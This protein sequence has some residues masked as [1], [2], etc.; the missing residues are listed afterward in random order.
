MWL[1]AIAL[2]E[3][4][5][6]SECLSSNLSYLAAMGFTRSPYKGTSRKLVLAFDIGTTYSGVSYALLDP[7]L[8]PEIKSVGRYLINDHTRLVAL[9]NGWPY[10]AGSW[11]TVRLE[12]S[13]YHPSC[14]TTM[15]EPSVASRVPWTMMKLKTSTKFDGKPLSSASRFRG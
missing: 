13:K 11:I 12:I 8:V 5:F 15:T 2:S 4:N 7:G 6:S 9:L 10:D 3:F 14:T 1:T